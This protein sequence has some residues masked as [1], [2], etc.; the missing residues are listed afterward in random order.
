MEPEGSYCNQKL[1][2][3]IPI[4]SQLD[5]VHTPT[6]HFLKTH[7][8]IILA[9]TPGVV[10]FYVYNMQQLKLYAVSCGVTLKFHSLEISRYSKSR[11]KIRS[12]QKGYVLPSNNVSPHWFAEIA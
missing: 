9:S 1:P 6:S 2:L 5:L 12:D 10:F 3:P 4:L 11:G 8:N 7:L